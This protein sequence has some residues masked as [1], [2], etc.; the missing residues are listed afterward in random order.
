MRNDRD[1]YPSGMSV[2]LESQVQHLTGLVALLV[3]KLIADGKEAGE[4]V[5]DNLVKVLAVILFGTLV[6]ESSA[7]G[8]QAL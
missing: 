2:S 8:Q 7:D 5:V 3:D 4:A 6:S 1:A